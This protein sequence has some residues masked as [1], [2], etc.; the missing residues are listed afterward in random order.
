MMS[1]RSRRC[2]ASFIALSARS[3]AALR[4]LTGRAEIASHSFL[5]V[6][7]LL[8]LV[9]GFWCCDSISHFDRNGRRV[10]LLLA[11]PPAIAK[12]LFVVCR[13]WSRCLRDRF[14]WVVTPT[15]D[16][17]LRCLRRNVRTWFG[18]CF[19]CRILC[20]R[21]A[22]LSSC[23]RRIGRSWSRRQCLC[24]A[25]GTPSVLSLKWSRPFV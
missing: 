2:A 23:E 7:Q 20:I 21:R 1:Q 13:C 17:R 10:L 8:S 15:A 14:S 18:P 24:M 12:D 9:K 5:S 6:W 22:A 11:A 3:K 16:V 25:H 19:Y 4:S